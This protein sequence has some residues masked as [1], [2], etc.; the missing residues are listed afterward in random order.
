MS[1]FGPR[2]KIKESSLASHYGSVS[3]DYMLGYRKI[4]IKPKRCETGETTE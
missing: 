4:K 3:L 1:K 2:I